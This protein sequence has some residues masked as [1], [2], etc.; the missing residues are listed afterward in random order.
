MIINIAGTNSSG[1][2]TLVRKLIASAAE[3][4]PIERDGKIIGHSLDRHIIVLGQYRDDLQTSGCDKIK[5]VPYTYSLIEEYDR[6]RQHVVYEGSYVMDQTRGPALAWKRPVTVI[7]LTTPI[8]QVKADLNARRARLGKP[9]KEDWK[10]IE[11]N[12]K[13]ARNFADKME[14]AG[15]LVYRVDRDMAWEILKTVTSTNA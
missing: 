15:A 12:H 8:E 7:R 5:D 4:L 3:S 9:P 6:Y 1:K 10:S 13:R 14:A 11:G 2:T